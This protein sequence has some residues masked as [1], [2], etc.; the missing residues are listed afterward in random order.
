M[1]IVI[2]NNYSFVYTSYA[3]YFILMKEGADQEAEHNY[4]L[5]CFLF[6]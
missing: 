1:L 2:L 4:K 6:I 5:P 3:R